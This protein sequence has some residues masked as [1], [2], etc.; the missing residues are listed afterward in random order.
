MHVVLPVTV[1]KQPPMALNAGLSVG[2]LEWSPVDGEK[3]RLVE[4]TRQDREKGKVEW[5]RCGQNRA[6]TE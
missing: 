2:R 5:G 4:V 1:I 3:G 6:V